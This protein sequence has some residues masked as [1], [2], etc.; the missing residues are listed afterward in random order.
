MIMAVRNEKGE[1]HWMDSACFDHV[2][3][4]WFAEKSPIDNYETERNIRAASGHR[5]DVHGTRKVKMLLDGRKRCSAQ[6]YVMDVLRPL[7]GIPRLTQQ[8]YEVTFNN[9]GGTS[10]KRGSSVN[11][12]TIDDI[13]AVR[14]VIV[15]DRERA[16]PSLPRATSVLLSRRI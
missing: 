5:L 16:L 12:E 14:V 8:G 3:P 11:F 10:S 2:C 15:K 9:T 6:F 13:F 4:K 7:L 1:Y